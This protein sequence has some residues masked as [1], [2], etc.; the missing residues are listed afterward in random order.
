MLKA[1]VAGERDAA[2]LSARALGSLR[3]KMPQLAG[4]LEGQ[5]TAHHATLIAGALELVDVLGR[6][7]S[8]MD[9]QR[10]ELLSPMAP[11]LE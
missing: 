9:Q 7:M 10:P 8:E 1:L 3:R 11:Q 6:Q 2:T 4:A 5:F